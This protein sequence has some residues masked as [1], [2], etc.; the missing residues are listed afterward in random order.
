MTKCTYIL[1]NRCVYLT[2]YYGDRGRQLVVDN[3][4]QLQTLGQNGFAVVTC[5]PFLH[6]RTERTM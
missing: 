2:D 1:S 6:K 3:R 4:S 5:M